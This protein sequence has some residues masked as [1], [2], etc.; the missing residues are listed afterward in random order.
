MGFADIA[1]VGAI[2]RAVAGN[3]PEEFFR[4]TKLPRVIVILI[5][6]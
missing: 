6:K 3:P 1:P 4:E 5:V 2:P